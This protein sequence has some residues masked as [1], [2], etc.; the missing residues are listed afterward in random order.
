[1]IF[2]NVVKTNGPMFQNL[3]HR[4]NGEELDAIEDPPV[5]ITTRQGTKVLPGTSVW[6]IYQE[7]ETSPRQCPATMH[8]VSSM[9]I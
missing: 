8:S 5:V 7:P 3:L 6:S 1:M 2:A 4:W 9:I